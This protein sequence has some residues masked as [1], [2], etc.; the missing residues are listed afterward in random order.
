MSH[1]TISFGFAKLS[2]QLDAGLWTVPFRQF[3]DLIK[4]NQK[5]KAKCT[6]G[7]QHFFF[8]ANFR[9][10]T[11]AKPP[12]AHCLAG[13]AQ[14]VHPRYALRCESGCGPPSSC[15]SCALQSVMRL[16]LSSPFSLCGLLGSSKSSS[17]NMVT[18]CNN[19]WDCPVAL[20]RPQTRQKLL[21]APQP[22]YCV[23]ASNTSI[24]S[25]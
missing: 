17:R 21:L 12:D 2:R 22:P 1:Y 11:D 23:I 25:S 7:A 20:A 19:S 4:D 16:R 8:C 15:G 9:S 3:A 13:V 5:A 24:L 6:R 10:P 14:G 18:A